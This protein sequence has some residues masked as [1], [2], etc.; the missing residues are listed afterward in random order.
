MIR[1]ATRAL[2]AT[3][4]IAVITGL[5]YPLAMT[6]VAQVAFRGS[7]D[8]SLIQ[9]GGRT[10]GS[11]LIGQA[12]TGPQWF[13]GRPSATSTPY[14]ASASSGSNLGPLSRTLA[15]D[16]RT[17]IDAILAIEGPYHAGLTASDIPVDLV[18]TSASGLDPD[19]SPAAASFQAPRVA[20]VRGIPLAEVER[21]ID[22]H[23][24]SRTLGVL[25][26]PRVNVLELN[27]ALQ[28]LGSG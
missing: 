9:S 13:Y 17:R 14:D 28:R 12:W 4:V 23:T 3:L 19:I 8:G 2:R 27:L 10:L 24:E 15:E 20:A 16:I 26:E 18:T 21:L 6:A 5:V 7:A 1:N 22:E 25:G 11:S